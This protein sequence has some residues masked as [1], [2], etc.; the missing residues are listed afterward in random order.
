MRHERK[1]SAGK[2]NGYKTHITKHVDSNI[3]TNIDVSSRNFPYGDMAK[4]LKAKKEFGIKTKSLTGD[5]AYGS[6][7]MR[8]EMSDEGIKLIS[9]TPVPR[10]TGKFSKEEFDID[11]EKEKVTCPKGKTTTRCYK[12]KNSEGEITKTFVFSKEVF[13][14]SVPGKMSAP[15]PGIP[16]DVSA[17]ALMRNIY[18]RQ[19]RYRKPKSLKRSITKIVHP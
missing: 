17:Q 8:K 7:K 16:E 19:E 12:S 13:V 15:M 5:G 18:R 6:G 1:S 10:D 14:R 4:P 9:K 2:F 11:L 3:I